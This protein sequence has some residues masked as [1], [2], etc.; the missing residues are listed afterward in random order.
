MSKFCR[1][2]LSIVEKEKDFPQWHYCETCDMDLDAADC[3]DSISTFK[4]IT[5]SPEMLANA[6]IEEDAELG[7][8][9]PLI[10]EWYPHREEAVELTLAALKKEVK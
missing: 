10:D 9:T 7:Y 8:T 6:I 3:V 5:A 1:F 2:C 4:K